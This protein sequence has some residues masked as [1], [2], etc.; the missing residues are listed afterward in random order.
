MI[1][2]KSYIRNVP[3]F[4]QPG[5]L[6]RDI[7]PL[8]REAF[9]ATIEALSTLLDER[10]W[11]IGAAWGERG[12]GFEFNASDPLLAGGTAVARYPARVRP[13]SGYAEGVAAL[14]GRPAVTDDTLSIDLRFRQ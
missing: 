5:I 12:R 2:L 11:R 4:P 10:E 13:I 14:A 3:D 8:L 6:F 9:G 1:D 7:S